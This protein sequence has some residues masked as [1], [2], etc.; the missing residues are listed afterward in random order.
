LQIGRIVKPLGKRLVGVGRQ[1]LGDRQQTSI[2]P[3]VPQVRRPK[4]LLRKRCRQTV[5]GI[6]PY[7]VSAMDLAA[8]PNIRKM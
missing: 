6:L 2:R 7:I 3:L 5:N 1:L 4:L 8:E